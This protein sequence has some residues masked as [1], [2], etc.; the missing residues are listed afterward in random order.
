M[1]PI[2]CRSRASGFQH[3]HSTGYALQAWRTVQIM[4]GGGELYIAGEPLLGPAP[5]CA[6]GAEPALLALCMRRYKPR[7]Q[8]RA[9]RACAW[10]VFRKACRSRCRSYVPAAQP[11]RKNGRTCF[12]GPFGELLRATGP[13]AKGNPLRF[14]NKYQDEETDL[15][16]YGYRYYNASVGRWLSRDPIHDAGF[17]LITDGAYQAHAHITE[18]PNGFLVNNPLIHFDSLGLWSSSYG[19]YAGTLIGLTPVHQRAIRRAITDLVGFE[20]DI[21]DAAQVKVDNDQSPE[22]SYEHAMRDGLANQPES[23]ARTLANRFVRTHLV[24]AQKLLC[25]CKP[26]LEKAL[27]HFGMALHTIQDFTS[28][29]HTGFQPWY[30]TRGHTEEALK[31]LF[32]EAYDPGSGSH[33]DI[34]TSW[35]WTFFACPTSAP[36]MPTD[37]FSTLGADPPAPTSPPDDRP[38]TLL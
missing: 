12:E 21:L 38:P 8:L 3:H 33:L 29:P 1:P 7:R 28:P 30:G 23:A 2:S 31:H 15:V 34:A 37:F 4:R 27:D 6:S 10:Q 36:R 32:A 5:P 14:S 17:R 22:L 20:Y 19:Y 9:P 25:Q 13:M 11:P 35:F 16:Y 18:S 24:Q 26:D